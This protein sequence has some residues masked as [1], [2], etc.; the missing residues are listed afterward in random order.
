MS[1]NHVGGGGVVVDGISVYV[2]IIYVRNKRDCISFLMR[3]DVRACTR[4][5][6][7]CSE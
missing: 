2:Y 1:E 7:T 4:M 3:K 6:D 5:T